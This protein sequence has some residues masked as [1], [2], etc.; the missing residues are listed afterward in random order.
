[1]IPLAFCLAVAFAMS[2]AIARN[3]DGMSS[4][5]GRREQS[6]D[7]AGATVNVVASADWGHKRTLVCKGC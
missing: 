7:D 2:A 5:G 4:I 1:M 3:R 6:I